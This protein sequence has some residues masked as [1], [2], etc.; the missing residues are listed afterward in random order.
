MRPLAVFSLAAGLLIG[1]SPALAD[2]PRVVASIKPVHS[3]VAGVMGGVAAPRLLVEAGQSPHTYALKPSEA[4]ALEQADLV[5]W[6]GPS[7]ESFLAR[8]VANIAPDAASFPLMRVGGLELLRTREGGSWDAHAHDHGGEAH[9]KGDESDHDHG[10]G[11]DHAHDHDHDHGHGHEHGHGHGHEHAD[12]DHEQAAETIQ[13][14][15]EPELDPHIWLDPDNARR[16]ARA[17]ADKLAALDPANADTY[18]ANAAAMAA[19]IREADQAVAR[20]VAPVAEV[21]YVVFH[22]A[23][24][25]FERH[26]GLSAVGSITLSPERQPSARRLIEIRDKI[27]DLSARCVFREPQFAPDLVRTVVENTPA[28]IGTLDP[29]GL[30]HEAGPGAYPKLL[31]DLGGNL[32]ACLADAS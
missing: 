7:L 20:Q 4:A 29:L 10:H 30:A 32:R 31:R 14:I 3:L 22:D 23:Y 28:D 17:L 24:Q 13:G 1:T 16:M 2:A 5:V 25:Y 26:Y 19:R 6:V 18:Q 27:A 8:P 9:A 12:A 21:P 15:P 11:H